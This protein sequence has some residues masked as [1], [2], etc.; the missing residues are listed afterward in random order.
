MIWLYHKGYSSASPFTANGA[1]TH[2]NGHLLQQKW[3]AVKACHFPNRAINS[4][5]LA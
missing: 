4:P 1:Q 5:Q 3:Q 2:S